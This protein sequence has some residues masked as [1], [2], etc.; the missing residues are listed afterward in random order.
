MEFEQQF[1]AT[2]KAMLRALASLA[3]G[4]SFHNKSRNGARTPGSPRRILLM[5]GAHIGDVIVATSVIPVLRSAYPSAEIGFLTG[6]WS[7]MIVK[8]HPGVT[9]TH[10]INHWHLNRGSE[11]VP[12]KLLQFRR[13]RRSALAR[14]RELQYDVAIAMYPHFPDF[15]DLSWDAGIPL[16]IGFRESVFAGLATD[17][18]AIPNELFV[19]QGA[20]LA[21][22]LCKLRIEPAHF[23]LRKSTLAPTDAA[24]TREVC[25]LLQ[26]S[27][28]EHVRY[29]IVHMGTGSKQRELPH[30]FWR[31]LVEKLSREHT[32][33]FTGLGAR[34][35]DNIV[36]IT[37]GLDRCVNACNRLSWDG[38]VAAVR[39]AEIVYGVESMAGHVAAAVGTRCVVVYSGAAGVARW[40]PEGENSVV[41]TNHVPCAPCFRPSGCASMTCIRGID[42]DDLLRFGS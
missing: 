8:E 5:N 7:H 18:V 36:S 22:L 3:H 38:F 42:P 26:V 41:F 37:R 21:Q 27:D 4:A 9:F 2:G 6:S 30:E 19:H 13:M 33:L 17:T 32:L 39:N 28:L 10:C 20:R 34:E 31:K 14:I 11:S 25:S 15:L 1:R 40:R 29:R 35:E 12:Q 16:R 24:S 23:L